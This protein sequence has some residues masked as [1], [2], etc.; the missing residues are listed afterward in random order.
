MKTPY[1]TQLSTAA[2]SA[3]AALAITSQT[4]ADTHTWTGA[5]DGDWND[6]GNWDI[7]IPAGGDDLIFS[8]TSNTAT[9][10]D[11]G[12]WSVTGIQFANTTAGESFSLGGTYLNWNGTISTAA[13]VGEGSITDTISL[14]LRATSTNR[15]FDLGA[16]HHIDVTG[17]IWGP[18]GIRKLGDGTL[19]L[20]GANDYAGSSTVSA[21]TLRVESQ[22]ALGSTG[23]ATT[24]AD[25][26]LGAQL[27]AGK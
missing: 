22:T 16:D 3:L 26:H 21:G 23:N 7:G 5:T 14:E 19:T 8:G 13:V 17:R 10:N 4:S 6:A 1:T 9:N 18:Q 11:V 2:L 24:V 12:V 15:N 27:H 25:G 20:S